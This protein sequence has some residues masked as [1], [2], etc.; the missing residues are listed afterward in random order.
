[1]LG[2]TS[3]GKAG[4]WRP[5]A[6]PARGRPA[7][8]S[9]ASLSIPASSGANGWQRLA[10]QSSRS[11]RVTRR[12]G[13][14]A[15]PTGNTVL[16]VC[17]CF[18]ASQTHPISAVKQR[19]SS[20]SPRC[21]SALWVVLS[22]TGPLPALAGSRGPSCASAMS[23][24]PPLAGR[25]GPRGPGHQS[26]T[27]RALSGLLTGQRLQRPE[28]REEASPEMALTSCRPR[29]STRPTPR[30]DGRTDGSRVPS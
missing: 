11:L 12:E 4:A 24:G 28:G 8:W 14:S 18:A 27:L 3:G 26:L 13:R 6:T 19:H 23:L 21:R 17:P 29:H 2:T 7:L 5:G 10:L 25:V 30:T 9:W 22:H 1:M 15:G 20:G 16:A